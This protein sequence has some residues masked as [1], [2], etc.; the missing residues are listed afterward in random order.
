MARLFRHGKD[1]I[2]VFYPSCLAHLRASVRSSP[3]PGSKIKKLHPNKTCP[4]QKPFGE[5]EI[6][7]TQLPKDL[8]PINLRVN[9]IT[10]VQEDSLASRHGYWV[11]CSP[12]PTPDAPPADHGTSNLSAPVAVSSKWHEMKWMITT[13]YTNTI[14][15]ILQVYCS[16]IP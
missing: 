9:G 2:A 12:N 11:K 5:I 3:T 14:C 6:R 1:A 10:H 8:E 15:I 4:I 7:W 13:T 16:N